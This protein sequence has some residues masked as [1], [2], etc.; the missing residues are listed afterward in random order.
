MTEKT[1][2]KTLQETIESLNIPVKSYR[3]SGAV[4]TA[5]PDADTD[6][7]YSLKCLSNP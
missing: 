3:E 7:I 1:L 6:K 4:D 5:N 2:I